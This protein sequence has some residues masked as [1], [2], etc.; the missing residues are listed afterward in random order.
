MY[1]PVNVPATRASLAIVLHGNPQT[2][3]ELLGQP[4]LRRVAD[5]TGT[6]LVAPFGRGIYAFEE[7]A[8]TDVYDLLPTLQ[9]ALPVDRGR[10]YLAGYSMGG[11][12]VF[13]IGPRGGYRWKAVLCISGAILNSGVR[14]V[15]LAWHDMPLYVVTGAHDD[16]IPTKYGE[17]TA[18]YLASLGLPVSFYEEPNGSHTLRSLMPSL[19]RAWTDMLAGT[20]RPDSVPIARNGV[21]LPPSA[22]TAVLKP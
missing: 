2:E 20:T 15:N 1:V 16:S 19:Q 18:G 13:K 5:S 17:Q 10:T 3:A 8:A 9:D 7:P 12:S 4:A 11:F 22:P 21:A 14:A 6:I